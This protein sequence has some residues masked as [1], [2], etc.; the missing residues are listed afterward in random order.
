[1]VLPKDDPVSYAT[2]S[3]VSRVYDD[4]KVTLLA[5]SQSFGNE[6]LPPKSTNL[7][8][9]FCIVWPF[10]EGDVWED[11][12]RLL[13][14]Y[15]FLVVF[16]FWC[17]KRR[18]F[19]DLILSFLSSEKRSFSDQKVIFRP[20]RNVLFQQTKSKENSSKKQIFIAEIPSR[21]L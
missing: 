21:R 17:A 12:S 3:A 20:E 19:F 13:L 9:A 8:T 18:S 14:F 2:P 1:M 16:L 7:S 15:S 4:P 10:S 11:V 6:N 5:I